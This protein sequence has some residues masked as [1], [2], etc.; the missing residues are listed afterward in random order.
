MES[1]R[2]VTVALIE[3]G[4]EPTPAAYGARA[5]SVANLPISGNAYDVHHAVEADEA[6]S[7]CELDHAGNLAVKGI[8]EFAH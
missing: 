3:R 4:L 8:I 2:F 7:W 1:G 5:S 6:D